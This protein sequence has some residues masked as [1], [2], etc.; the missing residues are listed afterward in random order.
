[1]PF[2]HIHCSSRFDRSLES[3]EHDLDNWMQRCSI[4]TLTEVQNN[5]RSGRL[6]EK[7]WDYYSAK[8]IQGADNCAIGWSREVWS[9][10]WQGVRKLHQHRWIGHHFAY[11]HAAAVLLKH[12]QRGQ[13][14]LVMCTHMPAHID[15]HG[16]DKHFITTGAG[17]RGRK[18]AYQTSIKNWSTWT[19]QLDRSKRPDGILVVADWNISLK[20]D[21]FRAYLKDH[22]GKD[23]K[24]G[25][26]HFGT[27]G[28]RGGSPRVIDGTLAKGLAITEGAQMMH[29]VRSSDH[30]PYI[31]SFDFA[32][33][34]TRSEDPG[35]T[36]HTKPGRAWW[37]F[38][39]YE[40]DDE[41]YSVEREFEDY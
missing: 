8:K 12:R 39:D 33:K 11:V 22:W 18:A 5:R 31:E 38:G 14:L 32:G 25:W 4:I 37:G 21:W 20:D 19:H 26:K 9:V 40:A 13:T 29:A 36:G 24:L 41:I 2:T 1:M 7:G 17:W 16:D 15:A 34:G 10:Q 6:R 27:M 23:Y 28:W 30:R 35:T 3:L